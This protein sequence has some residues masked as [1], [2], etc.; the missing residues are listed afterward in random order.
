MVSIAMPES[1]FA[2]YILPK[3]KFAA[4]GAIATAVDYVLYVWIVKTVD[5]VL[6]NIISYSIAVTVNFI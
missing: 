1:N 4:S 6:A 5:P 3:L 2:K